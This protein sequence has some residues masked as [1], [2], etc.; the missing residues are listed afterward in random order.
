LVYL[1]WLPIPS[2]DP[3]WSI[4]PFVSPLL[5]FVIES[6]SFFSWFLLLL[7]LFTVFRYDLFSYRS[8]LTGEEFE[9]VP[10][11]IPWAYQISR[12]PLFTAVVGCC[13]FTLEMSWSRFIFSSTLTVYTAIGCI[14]QERET[15]KVKGNEYKEYMKEVPRLMPIRIPR[16]RTQI[17][18][19]APRS[20][21]SAV[22]VAG[23]KVGTKVGV[24]ARAR[25]T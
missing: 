5:S 23:A 2:A 1:F 19:E 22:A 3:V 15:I 7:S 17:Q 6:M 25:A 14:L 8:S 13:W 11:I 10:Q 12:N 24:G 9:G 16:M 21:P 4:Q 20:R 18:D